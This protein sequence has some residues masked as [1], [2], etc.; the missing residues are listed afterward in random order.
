MK[1]WDTKLT[2]FFALFLSR[3]IKKKHNV[4]MSSGIWTNLAHNVD[5][6][7]VMI[8]ERSTTILVYNSLLLHRF[9]QFRESISDNFEGASNLY[10]LGFTIDFY[11][12]VIL[13]L[14]F[15]WNSQHK[16]NILISCFLLLI[17]PI[18]EQFF[19]Q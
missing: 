13:Y 8:D 16:E 19:A 14:K 18:D 9:R 12:Y 10:H 2:F 11:S 1:F 4:N 3:T 6:H 5:G 15:R 7:V 17:T